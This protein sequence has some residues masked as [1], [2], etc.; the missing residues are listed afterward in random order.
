MKTEMNIAEP[1]FTYHNYDRIIS[2]GISDMKIIPSAN[3]RNKYG[4]I[5]K[6][7]HESGEPIYLT[8]NGEGDLVV[9]SIE[10]YEKQQALLELKEKLLNIEF[11]QN[12]GS[13]YYSF[14]ELKNAARKIIDNGKI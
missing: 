4:E 6:Y 3:L 11:E 13:K 10:A 5:S 14:D 1:L 12:N 8:K 9:L 7:C 2:R